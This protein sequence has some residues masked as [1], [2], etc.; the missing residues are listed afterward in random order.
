MGRIV[1][2]E[3]VGGVVGALMA[4]GVVLGA[5]TGALGADPW[6]DA[7]VGYI[8]GTNP[9]PAALTPGTSVGSPERFT[10]EGVFPSVVT[11]FNAAF[12]SDELVSLGAGGVLTVG[13]DEAIV[14]DA[15]NPYGVDLLIFANAF[16]EDLG[17]QAGGVFGGLEGATVEVSADGVAWFPATRVGPTRPA[18]GY[19][20]L[21]D[22]YALLPGSVFSDFREPVDPAFDAVGKSFAQ[23]VAGY[24]TSGGGTGYD[25]SGTGLGAASFV[26]VTNPTGRVAIDAFSAVPGPGAA[27]VLG[28][29]GVAGLPRRRRRR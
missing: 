12:G 9:N 25:L 2:R 21:T 6:A 20:D 8:Q 4:G 16:Y 18:L 11:P 5:A 15:A 10:G 24:G 23:I 27:G 19:L 3:S 1:Q 28:A 26:R 13:F 17:D 7:V 29:A 22:R 14:D